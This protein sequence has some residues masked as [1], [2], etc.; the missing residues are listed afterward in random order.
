MTIIQLKKQND[1]KLVICPKYDTNTGLCTIYDSRPECCR[2]FPGK[3]K[4]YPFKNEI[5]HTCD[6]KCNVC[7]TKCCTQI[8]IP[9]NMEPTWEVVLT[10][11]QMSCTECPKKFC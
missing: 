11:L 7:L 1:I 9:I 6:S 4:K 5:V 2:N 8:G 3:G 10:R